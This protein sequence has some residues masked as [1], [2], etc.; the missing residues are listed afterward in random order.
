MSQQ[1]HKLS[2]KFVATV[3]QPGY[4]SDGGNL[5]LQVSTRLSKS[6]LFIYKRR[7]TG[8]YPEMGLGSL[9]DVSIKEARDHASELRKLLRKGIDPL[10]AKNAKSIEQELTRARSLFFQEA[11]E[12]CIA[13]KRADW[14]NAKHAAQWTNTIQTY[15]VPWIGETPVQDVDTGLVLKVLEP[16][17]QS[18]P[19]TATRLRAR[20]EA[21]L[22][23]ATARGHRT[24]ENPARWRGHL[25]K[26]LPVLKKKSRV[27]HHPALPYDDVPDFVRELRKE[28][29]TAA[30]ALELTIL[31]C[32]RTGEVI[33]A[34]TDEF[35]LPKG[36][37]TIPA[38]RMKAGRPH[39]VPLAPRSMEIVRGQ[40]TE[41]YVFPGLR[42]GHSLSNMAML[43]LLERMGRGDITVHG[44]RSSFR[45]WAAEK[46]SYPNH[47]VEMALA[48]TIGSA[49][50][51]AYRRG[52]LLEKR[53]QLM[54]DWARYCDRGPARARSASLKKKKA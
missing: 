45:D 23:W 3:R 42:D 10:E 9:N 50:E 49:V 5:Y 40:P 16:I 47:V 29:G 15:A 51:A 33:G 12:R 25:D 38:G 7:G 13:A 46:T 44:F 18:K 34:D 27:K 54:L 39:Q 22:D 1:L 52:H 26:L 19:E 41:G 24:G 37:W 30:R 31:T 2:A 43:G 4:H 36:I 20:L 32:T 28:Q 17:W 11:A 53:R 8:K 21:V 14:K 35:D 6:W 48:H